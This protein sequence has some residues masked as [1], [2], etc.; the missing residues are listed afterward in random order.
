MAIALD[1]TSNSG[2][3]TVGTGSA[4][5][6]S[7]SHTCGS[8][9]GMML[10]VRVVLSKT[11]AGTP[12]TGDLSGVTYAG[13]GMSQELEQSSGGTGFTAKRSVVYI[14]TLPAPSAGANTIDVNFSTLPNGYQ[15]KASAVSLSGVSST[16]DVSGSGTAAS[17]T[18]TPS[19]SNAWGVDVIGSSDPASLGADSPQTAD[20]SETGSAVD[21]GGSYFGPVSGS[22]TTGWSTSGSETAYAVQ[23]FA[24]LAI[25]DVSGSDSGTE[26]E[27][28]LL[29]QAATD[30]AT[31]SESGAVTSHATGSDAG[32]LSESAVVRQA[33]S[34]AGTLGEA[35]TIHGRVSES[36]SAALGEHGVVK[37][38]GSDAGTLGE[39]AR[40][41]QAGSDAGTLS[42]T[43]RVRESGADAGTLGEEEAVHAH[44][45]ATDAGTL[46]E[47]TSLNQYANPE[48]V[49]SG[50]LSESGSVDIV[51][52]T[53]RA[54]DAGT[55]SESASVRVQAADSGTMSATPGFGEFIA[56]SDSGSLDESGKVSVV[57]GFRNQDYIYNHLPGRFRRED[58][59]K[60]LLLYRFLGAAPAA[61]M[62]QWD[63]IMASFYEMINPTTAP[64]QFVIWWMFALFGWYW[65]PTW[66]TIDRMRSL[67][68]AF[69]LHLARR[70]TPRGIV[71]FLEAF[72]IHSR[73][74]ARPEVFGEFV[75][76]EPGW[77]ISAP[78]GVVV[79]V[80]SMDDEVNFD[81]Q[82][83][84]FGGVDGMVYGEGYYRET[85]PTLTFRQI[86]DLV[87]F[88]WPNGQRVMVQ[89]V[90]NP[91]VTTQTAWDETAPVLNES[92]VPDET[93]ET[94][95]GVS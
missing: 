92:W 12:A 3:E 8:G 90:L 29:R 94:V 63:A 42:E 26:T 5:T 35:E 39:S 38:A 54:T 56:G 77:A 67:Y 7:W 14:F 33:G 1:N 74:Y 31:L 70:G 6:L 55:L 66:F 78:L 16:L 87:R 10:V 89:Y 17:E 28:E 62:D 15:A 19:N 71:G 91:N 60:N 95:T 86:E 93:G 4:V 24:P 46:A 58:A 72:S 50:T 37:Q 30:S 57:G 18:L 41:S 69:T 68:A 36:D 2:A 48:R 40:V 83:E 32:T 20:W 22:T 80:Y 82:S 49:D 27:A 61:V 85:S 84:V 25:T 59:K 44:I 11:S 43:G 13:S 45:T 52:Q 51:E 81:V 65:Y 47:S 21:A 9:A 76:G 88:E 34:D 75:Y 79:Q 64:P 53:L 23:Y 73:V